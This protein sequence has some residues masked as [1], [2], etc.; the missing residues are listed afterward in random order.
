MLIVL[1]KGKPEDFGF[2]WTKTEAAKLVPWA[3]KLGSDP[4]DVQIIGFSTA[5]DR[6]AAHAKAKAFLA[7]REVA[8]PPRPKP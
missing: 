5:A 2:I 7:I 6:T 4:L 3:G 8:P 1:R